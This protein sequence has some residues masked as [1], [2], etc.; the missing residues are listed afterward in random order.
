MTPPVL[1][2]GF[3]VY[4]QQPLPYRITEGLPATDVE[5][6]TKG[7]RSSGH[8]PH[9]SSTSE[10]SLHGW[11]P[12]ATSLD[13]KLSEWNNPYVTSTEDLRFT[14]RLLTKPFPRGLAVETTLQ[15]FVIVTYWVDQPFCS[16]SV[17]SMM[18]IREIFIAFY[19]NG[20]SILQ[21]IYRHPVSKPNLLAKRV[22]G[23]VTLE[24]TG[25][26]PVMRTYRAVGEVPMA[27]CVRTTQILE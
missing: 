6:A 16:D 3:F 17:W 19:S 27:L 8:E 14:P 13:H 2:P 4:G 10:V 24:T 12:T 25:R 23:E 11:I 15:H 5:S 7:C 1:F 26:S 20:T 9:K 21:S 22:T 18:A